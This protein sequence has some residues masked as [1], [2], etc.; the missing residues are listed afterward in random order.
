[1][2][3]EV[4][5]VL[6]DERTARRAAAGYRDVGDVAQRFESRLQR[7]SAN[8]VHERRRRLPFERQRERPTDRLVDVNRLL[9]T[10]ERAVAVLLPA[11]DDLGRAAREAPLEQNA[12]ASG[13][14]GDAVD[15]SR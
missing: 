10:N 7:R 12:R 11:D 1:M 8:V 3:V 2:R 15:L 13:D 5:V 4:V 6:D 14:T 9:L